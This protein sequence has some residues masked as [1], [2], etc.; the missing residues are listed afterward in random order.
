VTTLF[1]PEQSK[2]TELLSY[3]IPYNSADVDSSPSYALY[4]PAPKA[5]LGSIMYTDIETALG[6]GWY[7]NVPDHEG[8]LA[9]FLEGVQEGHNVL[10]SVR[11][12]LNADCGLAKDA[13]YA[14][15]GY[16]GG[17]VASENAAEL[18]V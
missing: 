3:Q 18:Q 5:A 11:A 12:A 10:D 14:M 4:A 8:P 9:S 7:V 1:V 6:M 13:R 2:G 17:S 15:W 16:S